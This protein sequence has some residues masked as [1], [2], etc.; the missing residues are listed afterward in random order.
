M[1][2]PNKEAF[3]A[4]VVRAVTDVP[5]TIRAQIHS[6]YGEHNHQAVRGHLA[7]W[8]FFEGWR[9]VG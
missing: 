6:I 7:D 8:V 1:R 9:W 5:D 2:P 4:Q 3:S